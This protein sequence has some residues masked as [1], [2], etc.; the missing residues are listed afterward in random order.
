ME[1]TVRIS[2]G[3]ERPEETII[4]IFHRHGETH[5]EW[6]YLGLNGGHDQLCFSRHEE[7]ISGVEIQ[8]EI[9]KLPYHYA[10]LSRGGLM[11]AVEDCST[12]FGVFVNNR[13]VHQ[14]L[15]LNHLDVI[16]IGRTLF[17]YCGSILINNH[18]TYTQNQWKIDI[19][20]KSVRNLFKKKILL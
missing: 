3:D 7:E 14:N 8:P 9:D 2:K 19:R 16:C 18:K 12:Q 10:T 13:P 11:W 1:D 20:E 4:L 6:H 15:I 5:I 17:I